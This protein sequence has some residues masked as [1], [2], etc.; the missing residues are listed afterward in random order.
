MITD[1]SIPHNIGR[2]WNVMMN[3]NTM[4]VYIAG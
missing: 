3:V 2:A 4:I 1:T